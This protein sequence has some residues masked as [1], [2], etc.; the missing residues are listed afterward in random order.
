MTDR[1]MTAKDVAKLLAI[2]LRKVYAIKSEIGYVEL[3]GNVRFE[4]TAVEAYIAKCRR[5]PVTR[6]HAVQVHG[7]DRWSESRRKVT[8]ADITQLL[9][10][11][12]RDRK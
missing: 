12:R 9:E 11:K 10:K 2:S 3:G 8:A 4:R 7:N 1:L 5:E 6:S